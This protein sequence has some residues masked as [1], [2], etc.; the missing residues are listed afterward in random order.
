MM[1]RFTAFVKAESIFKKGG[2]AI[3]QMGELACA[4]GLKK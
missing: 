4:A 3:Q 2:I 1:E